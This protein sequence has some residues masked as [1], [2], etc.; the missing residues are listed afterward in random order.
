MKDT[1]KMQLSPPKMQDR[2]KKA[3]DRNKSF[4]GRPTSYQ[5]VFKKGAPRD[6]HSPLDPDQLN[7]VVIDM[8]EDYFRLKK[9]KKRDRSFK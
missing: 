4:G 3:Q 2:P 9:E 7:K 1:L 8:M 5:F 6:K